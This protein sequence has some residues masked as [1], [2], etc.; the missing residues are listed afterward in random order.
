M[1][2]KTSQ[3][4]AISA[5]FALRS[6]FAKPL[7]ST[8]PELSITINGFPGLPLPGDPNLSISAGIFRCKKLLLPPVKDH[9]GI[10][11]RLS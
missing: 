3:V 2:R 8:L 4:A 5:H 6:N 1:Q 10:R 9:A 11:S 7:H